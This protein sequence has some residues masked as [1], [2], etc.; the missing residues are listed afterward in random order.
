MSKEIERQVLPLFSR[1]IYIV[2]GYNL[3]KEEMDAVQLENN[4]G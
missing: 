4:H 2:K 3:N 1:P